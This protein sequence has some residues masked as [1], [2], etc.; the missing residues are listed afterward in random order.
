MYTTLD[1]LLLE[2]RMIIGDTSIATQR[3]LDDWLL[4]AL[5]LAVKLSGRYLSDKY[6]FT[7]V[8]I[9]PVNLPG[10]FV[11]VVQRNPLKANVFRF[12]VEEGVIEKRDEPVILILAAICVLEG[13]LENSAWNI[14]SWKDAEV[15]FSNI[16]SGRMKTDNLKRLYDQL[17]DLTLPPTKR[18]ATPTKNSLPGYKG[19][20]YERKD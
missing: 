12:P 3:Y 11:E 5:I 1:Y 18:L 9:D 15:S 8:E 17:H 4:K 19:N 2:L 10:V 16:E 20:P 6:I 14:G 13:S 7:K